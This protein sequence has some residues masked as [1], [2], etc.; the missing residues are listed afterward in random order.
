MKISLKQEVEKH[1]SLYGVEY[2]IE[3]TVGVLLVNGRGCTVSEYEVIP[4]TLYIGVGAFCMCIGIKSV[5]MSDSCVKGIHTRAFFGCENLESV[6]FPECLV[7]VGCSAF[8]G[9]PLKELDLP[10][11]LDV[12]DTGAFSFN[13]ELE[14]ITIPQGVTEIGDMAFEG[15]PKLSHAYLLPSM[16][17]SEVMSSTAAVPL[18]PYS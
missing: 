16:T 6:Y 11:S 14:E 17:I 15:C 10:S 18:K 2:V 13:N 9:C 12:I 8:E 1:L 4:E 5:D 7:K 3:P